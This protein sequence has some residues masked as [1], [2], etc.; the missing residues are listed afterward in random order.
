MGKMKIGNLQG[1]EK[2]NKRLFKNHSNPDIDVTKSHLNYDLVSCKKS[3][4]NAYEDEMQ[5]HYKSKRKVRSDATVIDEWI[6]SASN[7]FFENM[8][9]ADEKRYFSTCL[10]FMKEKYGHVV[11]ATVHKDETTPHMHLG[12]VPLTSDGRL[13]HKDIFTRNELKKLHTALYE[14]LTEEG[15]NLE[16][17]QS[18]DKEHLTVMEFKAKKNEELLQKQNNAIERNYVVI[19]KQKKTY[20]EALENHQENLKAKEKDYLDGL[21]AREK[22]LDERESTYKA[23]LSKQYQNEYNERKK[24]LDAFYAK[25][26]ARLDDRESKLRKSEYDLDEREKAIDERD[27]EVERKERNFANKCNEA[28]RL[29]KNADRIDADLN[30]KIGL[31]EQLQV[32]KQDTAI[33]MGLLSSIKQVYGQ[34]VAD[35]LYN[36]AVTGLDAMNYVDTQALDDYEQFKRTPKSKQADD[37]EF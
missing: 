16:K 9:E 3:Y 25:E 6:F 32:T 37:L 5:E 8:S 23:V 7:D 28:I 11:Y 29:V 18:S 27:A 22:D 12:L 26:D 21:K 10:D 1:I 31:Y 33:L 36:K 17:P 15:F 30:E 4:K 24:A 35:R 2:H 19:N 14:R 13:S 34:S 20:K